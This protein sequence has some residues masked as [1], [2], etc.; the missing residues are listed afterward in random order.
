MRLR[1]GCV[2]EECTRK[3]PNASFTS[4]ELNWTG[5]WL[6]QCERTSKVSRLISRSVSDVSAGEDRPIMRAIFDK[7]VASVLRWLMNIHLAVVRTRPR[8]LEL[9]QCSTTQLIE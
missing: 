3:I 5:Q 6:V 9:I 1:L 8:S 4:Y 7:T 2:H